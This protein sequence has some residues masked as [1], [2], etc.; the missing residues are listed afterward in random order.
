MVCSSP[1]QL[2]LLARTFLVPK[3]VIVQDRFVNWIITRLSDLGIH[4]IGYILVQ[5]KKQNPNRT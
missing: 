2:R 4:A 5:T 3:P 1:K